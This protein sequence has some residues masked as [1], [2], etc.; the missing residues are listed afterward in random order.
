LN[1][2]IVAEKYRISFACVFCFVFCFAF[3]S[4]AEMA[5]EVQVIE[6]EGA[7]SVFDGNRAV[8]RNEAV[9][10]A[11]RKTVKRAIGAWLPKEKMERYQET[12][13]SQIYHRSKDYIQ[14]FRIIQEKE[15]EGVYLVSVTASV[16]TGVLRNELKALGI[17]DGSE[18]RKGAGVTGRISIVVRGIRDYADY[19]RVREGLRSKVTQIRQISPRKIEDHDV[20]FDVEIKEGL[21]S[22][23]DDISK[24][25]FQSI[26]LLTVKTGRDFI[27]LRVIY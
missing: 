23:P 13:A 25:D 2:F 12:L 17:F 8:A 20:W 9:N 4:P 27:E 19:A 24:V 11:L 6:A 15:S 16:S 7:A 5:S 14:N 1:H 21:E 3:S 26:S 10:E 18:S 22:L